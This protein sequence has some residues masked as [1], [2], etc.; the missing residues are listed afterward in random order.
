[1]GIRTGAQKLKRGHV[2][3]HK[4]AAKAVHGE[5]YYK[6]V[7]NRPADKGLT[8]MWLIQGVLQIKTEAFIVAMQDGVTKVRTY[9]QRILKE[10]D[11]NP[12]TCMMCK[13]RK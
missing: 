3:A 8:A 12:P 5:Y 4:Q 11:V 1:M 7:S 6:T 2:L 9:R 13:E 10:E